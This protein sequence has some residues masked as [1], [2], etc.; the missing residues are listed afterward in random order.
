MVLRPPGW[1]VP[2]VYVQ[3]AP[4][5]RKR[6]SRSPPFT[7][8]DTC[9]MTVPLNSCTWCFSVA[10]C[11]VTG[12][13]KSGAL[14]FSV[15]SSATLI[16][17]L[18]FWNCQLKGPTVFLHT[19]MNRDILLF[20]LHD[21]S[22]RGGQS[23]AVQGELGAICPGTGSAGQ[24][25]TNQHIPGDWQR[26]CDVYYKTKQAKQEKFKLVNRGLSRWKGVPM[27]DWY[28]KA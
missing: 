6:Q 8:C 13:F 9:S 21:I 11:I 20:E 2:K 19:P 17:L 23:T 25:Q 10:K 3:Y 14:P 15:L 28:F 18:C 22:D 1:T 12:L 16:S 26:N 4:R 5:W 7:G 24:W 27:A